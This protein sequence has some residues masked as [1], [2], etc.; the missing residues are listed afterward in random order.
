MLD[1]E[2]C[3]LVLAYLPHLSV[4]TLQEI[5]WA[6]GM[7]KPV[8]MMT[9]RDDLLNHPILMAT[10]PFRFDTRKEGWRGAM[11]TIDGLYGVYS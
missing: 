11:K 9:G 5:G 2:R 10:V 6:V 3:D 1:V 7:K 8:V 4:G